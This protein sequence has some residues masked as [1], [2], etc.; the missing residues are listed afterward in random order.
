MLGLGE[1]ILLLLRLFVMVAFKYLSGKGHN[2][3][4][5]VVVLIVLD[6]FYYY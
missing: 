1:D 5:D 6:I 4:Y 3:K 2:S